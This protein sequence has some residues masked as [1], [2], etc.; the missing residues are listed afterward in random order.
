M[1]SMGLVLLRVRF[2]MGGSPRRMMMRISASPLHQEG[3]GSPVQ[4]FTSVLV[5][6]SQELALGFDRLGLLLEAT[7]M[8]RS[9]TPSDFSGSLP[10]TFAILCCWR[11]GCSSTSSAP[12]QGFEDPS[13]MT[14]MDW[15][16]SSHPL[17]EIDESSRARNCWRSP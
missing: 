17:L 4:V 13:A 2:S 5:P 3:A 11:T 12:S 6:K 10:F 14:R 7:R 1:D 16:T 9:A 8:R 15:R